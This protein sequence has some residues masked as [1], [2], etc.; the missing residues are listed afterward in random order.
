MK[1]DNE[2][3]T[4]LGPVQNKGPRYVGPPLSGIRTH[5]RRKHPELT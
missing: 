4:P 1:M 3:L 2:E 5:H